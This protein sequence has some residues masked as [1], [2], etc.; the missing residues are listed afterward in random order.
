MMFV[1]YLFDS[2]LSDADHHFCGL[3]VSDWLISIV[4]LFLLTGDSIPLME[5]L[6]KKLQQPIIQLF[7]NIKLVRTRECSNQQK[8]VSP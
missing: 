5:I 3:A 8:Q 6:L 1:D 2:L 7:R 4:V